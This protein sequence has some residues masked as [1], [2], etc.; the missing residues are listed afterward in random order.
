MTPDVSPREARSRA[1]HDR[2][3]AL[4]FDVVGVADARLPLDRD[5][6]H[7]EAFLQKGYAGGMSWLANDK[8]LRRRV[9]VDGILAGAKS[10]V[11]LGQR[12]Q[13][14]D[15][16][17]SADPPLARTIARYARG[18]DYHNGLRKKLRSLAKF[19]R[20]LEAGATA[21]PLTDD[22][23]ILERAW[24]AR[25]GLGFVG[26]NG[27][28]IVPGEGSFLLLGEVVTTVELATG[29]P[30]AERCGSCRACL[31]A[32]PTNAF[33]APFVL[34][35][36][37]CISY[38][39]IEHREAIEIA[40]RPGIGEHLFGCD[41]CQTVCPFNRGGRARA[42]EI[43]ERYRPLER[44]GSVDLRAVLLQRDD[45][46]GEADGDARASS[47]RAMTEGSPLHRATSDGLARNAA[48]V[49]G[50]RREH[51]ARDD[52]FTVARSHPSAI[53]REAATWALA[54]IDGAPPPSNP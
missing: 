4:G 12:Y 16:E 36:R 35:P 23:P 29:T 20:T 48:I 9:D 25:A 32:C 26:K 11:C 44:W 3:R 22:A 6:A 14:T 49:L 21:R 13:R 54:C 27:M 19:L 17:E 15:A 2:A 41:D 43:A 51:G 18:R 33:V 34:D 5:M 46:E 53:V 52:L 28:M 37:R 42:R 8:E 47:F 10:V 24:A 38:L 7:Y 31:D 45:D 1:V 30:M 50:N 40:L 39:T